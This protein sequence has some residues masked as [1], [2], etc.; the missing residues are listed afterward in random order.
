M[1]SF[2]EIKELI[3]IIDNSS[4]RSFE[5]EENNFKFKLSKNEKNTKENKL[6]E[7]KKKKKSVVIEEKEIREEI[8]VKKSEIK[9]VSEDC[10]VIK[11]LLVG[12]YYSSNEPGGKPYARVGDKVKKG[13]VLC[14]IEA[15]KIM[16]EIVS[17]Y[18][19]EIVEV[20]R[21][22]EDIVEFG[23]ELFKIK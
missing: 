13:D 6:Y 9:E 8:K 7:K 3:N 23:M 18:D 14:I 16:N 2:D 17:E 5:L 20:L 10:N 22:D 4:L 12:T 15:M 1:L 21:V 19:G 11:S